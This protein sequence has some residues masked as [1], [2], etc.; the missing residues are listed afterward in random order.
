MGI[1]VLKS[2]RL[3]PTDKNLS[4]DRPKLTSLYAWI[5]SQRY[6]LVI[7]GFLI[8]SCIPFKHCNELLCSVFC[9]SG[10]RL[11]VL[12]KWRKAP[13][14]S[15][16]LLL[17]LLLFL[18]LFP[19]TSSLVHCCKPFFPCSVLLSLSCVGYHACIHSQTLRAAFPGYG[20]CSIMSTGCKIWED[21][22]S[23]TRGHALQ[24]QGQENS[25][26]IE[27]YPVSR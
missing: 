22:D 24:R 8:L 23:V 11:L 26:R 4:I 17:L 9:L 15:M 20:E 16:K 19:L 13:P 21:K 10:L 7:C 14:F 25:V 2:R 27:V 5:I 3:T 1:L 18:L 12:F 6:R